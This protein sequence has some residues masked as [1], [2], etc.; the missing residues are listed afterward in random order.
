MTDT[1]KVIIIGG[2]VS[3]LTTGIY[4][5]KSGYDVEILE[6]NAIPGGACVGWERKGCY[7]D[8]CIHWLVGTKPGNPYY[9]F[10]EKRMRSKK[11]LRCSSTTLFPCSISPTER[12]LRYMR[13]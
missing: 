13:I 8:G 11:T 5:R 4:L 9:E 2:G 12:N 1:K 10:G 3:G 7:I 6:K